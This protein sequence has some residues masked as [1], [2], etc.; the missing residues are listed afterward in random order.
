MKTLQEQIR[1]YA[2]LQWLLAVGLLLIVIAFICVL[3]VPSAMKLAK[4]D[5]FSRERR[6]QLSESGG[7]ARIL[8]VIKQDVDRLRLE[9]D[10]SK[11]LP[12]LSDMPK[13][14]GD[15]TELVARNG[16]RKF[17]IKP[18]GVP[19]RGV[20][21]LF[22][23]SPVQL[24]FEADYASLYNFLHQAEDLQRLTRVKQLSV[25]RDGVGDSQLK[26]QLSMN[27]YFSPEE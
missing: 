5:Q 26:V 8:P 16:L 12:P 19:Q 23:Y 6:E 15:L 20:D 1:W 17:S 25:T 14:I 2:R 13:F 10:R 18:A 24:V 4:L 9:L 11:Q 27:L 21:G 7:R 3:Y 22:I